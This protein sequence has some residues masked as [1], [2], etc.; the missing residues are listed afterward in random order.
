MTLNIPFLQLCNLNSHDY[1]K[2]VVITHLV[3]HEK[4]ILFVRAKVEDLRQMVAQRVERAPH[5]LDGFVGGEAEGDDGA[6]ALLAPY[7]VRDELEEVVVEQ[8]LLQTQHLTHELS[9]RYVRTLR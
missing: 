2:N 5:L 4:K 9:P 8:V 3:S 6:H 1:H 7:A